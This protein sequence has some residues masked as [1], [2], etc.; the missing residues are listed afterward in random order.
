M[1]LGLKDQIRLRV[2]GLTA[3][4]GHWCFCVNYCQIQN[5]RLLYQF[6]FYVKYVA[7]VV[8]RNIQENSPKR[9]DSLIC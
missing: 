3:M 2:E 5:G 4:V 9:H 6:A 1:Y 8:M 7:R